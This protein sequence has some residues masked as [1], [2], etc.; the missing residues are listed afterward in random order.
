MHT[1]TQKNKNEPPRNFAGRPISSAPTTRRRVAAAVVALRRTIRATSWAYL[2]VLP[3]L[4]LRIVGGIISESM[5][6]H[7]PIAKVTPAYGISSFRDMFAL[8]TFRPYCV[9]LPKSQVLLVQHRAA[10]TLKSDS[11]ITMP[12]VLSLHLSHVCIYHTIC[13]ACAQTCICAQ[14]EYIMRTRAYAEHC[15]IYEPSK[16]RAHRAPRASAKV[17]IFNKLTS[18][19][20]QSRATVRRQSLHIFVLLCLSATALGSVACCLINHGLCALFVMHGL[21]N[22]AAWTLLRE[23]CCFRIYWVNC[24]LGGELALEFYDITRHLYVTECVWQIIAY[25]MNVWAIS[26]SDYIHTDSM[27]KCMRL[28]YGYTEYVNVCMWN[29]TCMANRIIW[30]LECKR[31]ELLLQWHE[32]VSDLRH[33]LRPWYGNIF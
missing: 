19:C 33:K 3:A 9:H 6:A 32:S 22:W 20:T 13:G 10:C 16:P 11:I 30:H 2:C 25:S 7:R 29:G 1:Q 15:S 12:L 5:F 21:R 17:S 23:W 18:H 31:Y 27:H 8:K 26:E 4:R 14:H 24:D 28:F